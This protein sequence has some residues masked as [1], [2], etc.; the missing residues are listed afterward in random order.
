[1]GSGP[2][3]AIVDGPWAGPRAMVGALVSSVAEG[4]RT[5][6]KPAAVAA[7]ATTFTFP[8]L[9]MLAVFLFLLVQH[10]VDGR[11]PKLRQAP[12]TGAD[13]IVTFV[14]EDTL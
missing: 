1:M 12:L 11:D 10:R 5:T 13:T 9:L 8:L 7:V 2:V 3:T 4:V 14:D 6:V